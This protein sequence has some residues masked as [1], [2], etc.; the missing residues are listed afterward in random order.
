MQPWGSSA[1]R[2]SGHLSPRRSFQRSLPA[3]AGEKHA[4]S[5][6]CRQGN[7]DSRMSREFQNLLCCAVVSYFPSI[8]L[9]D[10]NPQAKGLLSLGGGFSEEKPLF[11]L[12]L[13][14]M[15]KL[16]D[17][18]IH[19]SVL[20]SIAPTEKSLLVVSHT[21][22]PTALQDQVHVFSAAPRWN[23]SVFRELCTKNLTV[24]S[25]TGA[26]WTPPCPQQASSTQHCISM[27][28]LH[29]SQPPGRSSPLML[30]SQPC[31]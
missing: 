16:G 23:W 6:K 31:S 27:M 30:N 2:S 28:L 13:N 1:P 8:L 10:H 24:L 26:R 7:A 4:Y 20:L 12:K 21:R 29:L 15:V 25:A 3:A 9:E 11:V 5:W 14:K 18:I 22:P 17:A 19:L